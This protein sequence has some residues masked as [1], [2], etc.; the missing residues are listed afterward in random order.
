MAPKEPVIALPTLVLVHGGGM[1][2]DSWGLVVE[3]IHPL[4]PELTVVALDMPGRRKPNGGNR[5]SR[6]CRPASRR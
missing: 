5:A 3:E 6:G 1:A 2:A 4:A